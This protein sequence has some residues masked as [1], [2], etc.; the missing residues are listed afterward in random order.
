M[1][2]Q[3]LFPDWAGVARPTALASPTAVRRTSAA[4]AEAPLRSSPA[5][6]LQ[7]PDGALIAVNLKK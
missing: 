6:H 1:G 2:C 3:L 4:L 7:Y 5:F